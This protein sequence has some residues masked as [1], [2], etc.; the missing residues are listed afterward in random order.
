MFVIFVIITFTIIFR[1]ISRITRFLW[2]EGREGHRRRIRALETRRRL[3]SDFSSI[4]SLN[5]PSLPKRRAELRR[6]LT[7]RRSPESSLQ[8]KVRPTFKSVA[9]LAGPTSCACSHQ[10]RSFVRSFV[11]AGQGKSLRKETRRNVSFPRKRMSVAFPR[12]P[13]GDPPRILSFAW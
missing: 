7:S 4:S 12:I 9:E 5:F 8:G 3:V 6:P 2:Q 13:R 11:F 1:R 10:F